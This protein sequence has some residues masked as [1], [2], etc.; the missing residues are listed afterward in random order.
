VGTGTGTAGEVSPSGTILVR[1]HYCKTRRLYM[2]IRNATEFKKK[3]SGWHAVLAITGRN[4]VR[5]PLKARPVRLELSETQFGRL[6]PY[7]PYLP[8]HGAKV[9]RTLPNEPQSAGN[10]GNAVDPAHCTVS[11]RQSSSSSASSHTRESSPIT[12]LLRPYDAG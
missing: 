2:H 6:T 7:R 8:R 9:E 12:A 10:A 3:K 11:I 4:T 5:I 1:V